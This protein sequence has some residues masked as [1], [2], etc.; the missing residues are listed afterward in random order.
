MALAITM[1]LDDEEGVIPS[2]F[3]KLMIRSFPEAYKKL[4]EKK[5]SLIIS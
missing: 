1:E 2:F 4:G 5:S 3:K